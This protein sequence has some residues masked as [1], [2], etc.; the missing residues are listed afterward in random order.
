MKRVTCFDQKEAKPRVVRL[1]RCGYLCQ[2]P[3]LSIFLS[4]YFFDAKK[5]GGDE[6]KLRDSLPF[7]PL[8]LILIN[9]IPCFRG[10]DVEC[11]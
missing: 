4:F 10:Y 5:A 9:I 8:L 11:K 1:P 7:R 2:S 6:N 3:L